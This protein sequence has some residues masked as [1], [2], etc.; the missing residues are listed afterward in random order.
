MP[1]PRPRW[2]LI[3]LV[4]IVLLCGLLAAPLGWLV[5]ASKNV[6]K[7]DPSAERG[8]AAT[9]GL[10]VAFLLWMLAWSVIRVRR[11]ARPCPDCGRRFLPAARKG[12]AAERC[13]QCRLRTLGPAALKAEE[14]KGRNVVGVVLICLMVIVGVG[15]S[16]VVKARVGGWS[17]YVLPVVAAGAVVGSL[18]LLIAAWI[19]VAQVRQRLLRHERFALGRARKVSGAFGEVVRDGG[20]M[21]WYSGALD[22]SP[23]LDDAEDSVRR[24]A[25]AVLGAAIDRRAALRVLAFDRR[26]A[27]L[28]FDAFGLARRWDVDG[29]RDRGPVP[30]FFFST[31]VVPQR[32]A[33]PASTARLLFA[34]AAVE[35]LVPGLTA[36]PWLQY[37]LASVLG[38]G[39]DR[40]EPDRLNR[41]MLA[42]LVTGT[43]SGPELFAMTPGAIARLMNGWTLLEN[44]IRRTQFLFQ[45]WSLV[46]YLVG[47]AA[48]ADRKARFRAFVA[49]LRP[50]EPDEAAFERHFGHGHDRLLE[51]WREWVRGRGVGVH[52]PPPVDVCEA[53]VGRVVPIVRDPTARVM[54][55]VVAVR[56]LGRAGYA[57]G[58]DALIDLLREPGAIPA[59]EAL[60]SL[61]AI[62]GMDLGDE[63]AFWSAWLAG[64]PDGVGVA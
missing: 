52:E 50:R 34:G 30:T 61:R 57:A 36:R 18:V 54:D 37:G 58:A 21:V 43:A 15:L 9:A 3:D 45:S 4:M 1:A 20:R 25:A 59:E 12:D 51:L 7:P 63:P 47:D 64:L 29:L 13:A 28:R 31:E 19:V 48:P 41:K 38:A 14:R 17:R 16:G 42:A 27:F 60:W 44:W 11:K 5:A 62:A 40:D 33:A 53:I 8:V 2:H 10:G 23:L 26:E 6:V 35:A 56:E 39:N 24:R 55:R 49:D 32:L 22:P 46:D